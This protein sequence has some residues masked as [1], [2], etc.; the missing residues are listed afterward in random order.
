MALQS[1]SPGQSVDLPLPL[2][3]VAPHRSLSSLYVST[4]A[5]DRF[6][7]IRLAASA[8]GVTLSLLYTFW[9]ATQQRFLGAVVLDQ[10]NAHETPERVVAALT[11]VPGVRMIATEGPGAGLAA[12]ERDRLS[13]AGTPVVVMA[14]PFL[15]DT[16]KLLVESLGDRA[17]AL[18][19]Q[20]GENAGDQAAAGVPALV[21]SLGL[22][23]TPALVRARFYDLQVFGWATIVAL[24]VDDRFVGEA[25]LANDFEALAWHG[26]ATTSTCHWIRGFL[27]GSL[28]S[29]TGHAIQVSEPDCQGKG[30]PRCRMVFRPG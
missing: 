2:M 8:L 7:A 15:G 25:L 21:A 12:F 20:A 24:Q 16:H 14:R 10:T 19:F 27:T 1:N 23:L 13:V 17:E 4:D 29:L 18:F 26:Q 30:D 5:I 28:S 3:Y 22:S 9:D 6:E 11:Q